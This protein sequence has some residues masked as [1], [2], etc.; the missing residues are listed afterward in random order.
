MLNIFFIKIL[1]FI[2]KTV[3]FLRR[4]IEKSEKVSGK[5]VVSVGNIGFGGSGKTPLVIGIARALKEKDIIPAIFLRGYRGEKEKEG[6]EVLS[7][8]P[9]LYG[10]EACLLKRN[11]P[12][13]RIF[14]G[15]DR[16][17]NMKKIE[18]KRIKV[19]LLDDGFQYFGVKKD[20]EIIIFDKEKKPFLRRDFI[21]EIRKADFVVKANKNYDFSF[22]YS[23]KGVYNSLDKSEDDNKIFVAFCGIGNPESFKKTLQDNKILF[24]NFIVFPD[25]YE[26]KEKDIKKL[27]SYGRS[28]ITTEKDFVKLEKYGIKELYYLKIETVLSEKFKKEFLEKIEKELK[29]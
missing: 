24:E 29:L 20:V 22:H 5:I 18:D 6:G 10:D 13:L 1:E 23:V 2:Y 16:V 27:L 21:F 9:L 28:L 26:Y 3:N 8:E 17:K 11:L 4:R 12:K 7:S 15:K 14:V 19:F 25:H